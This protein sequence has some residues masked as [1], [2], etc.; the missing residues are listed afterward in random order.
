MHSRSESV[1][2][3]GSGSVWQDRAFNAA[4]HGWAEPFVDISFVIPALNEERWIEPTLVDLARFRTRTSLA[5]EVVVV[6]GRSTDSTVAIATRFAD[7]VLVEPEGRGTIARARN[8]GGRAASGHVIVHMDADS[9]LPLLDE[10]ASRAIG[11]IKA[12]R[13][14]GAVVGLAPY[15]WEIGPLDRPM[16]AFMNCLTRVMVPL[17]GWFAKGECQI[18]D[19][20]VY[21]AAGG[22]DE[23]LVAGED[24]D[25][26]RRLAKHGTIRVLPGFIVFHSCRRFHRLGYARVFWTYLRQA[27]SLIVLRRNY[28]DEWSEVR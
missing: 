4:A 6:D 26:F 7:L 27:Y 3:A 16:H 11:D 9:R 15:P 25:M 8:L 13:W 1:R 18:V 21:L 24:C 28:V 19:R 5:V 17:G 10:L 20:N 23:S 12:G 2:R 22:Y 14:V